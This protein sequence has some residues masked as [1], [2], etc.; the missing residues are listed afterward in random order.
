MVQII[1]ILVLLLV[2]SGCSASPSQT[3]PSIGI[4]ISLLTGGLISPPKGSQ[5]SNISVRI[6]Q[7]QSHGQAVQ[8]EGFPMLR[9]HSQG[10][11]VYNEDECIGPVVNNRCHG[12]ILP[13]GG[14]RKKCYGEWLGGQCTGPMF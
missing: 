2:G 13:K 7:R 1:S 6:G 4:P 3:I 5:N 10:Q 14:Y 9:D 12:S 11:T 8:D